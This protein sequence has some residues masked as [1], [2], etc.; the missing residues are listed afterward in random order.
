V[1]ELPSLAGRLGWGP[2]TDLPPPE[3]TPAEARDAADGV[4]ARPEYNWGDQRGLVERILDWFGDRINDL[5]ES[6]GIGGVEGGGLSVWVAWAVLA[7][8][9]LVIAFLVFRSRSGW[10]RDRARGGGRGGPVVVTPGEEAVDWAAEAARC[11][12]EGRWREALRARYRVLV[13]D[14]AERGLIGD[15]VGRT[16]GELAAEVRERSPDASRAFDPAT[17]M[18][19]DAW[20]GAVPVGPDDLARFAGLAEAAQA[21]AARGRGGATVA[22]GDPVGAAR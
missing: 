1:P 22:A 12:A 2:R 8:I 4:L 20:Y 11:E 21:A 3:H 6:L 7:V 18:F 10:R 17:A 19:E 15:L 13:G 5:V 14:L 16:A 9:V